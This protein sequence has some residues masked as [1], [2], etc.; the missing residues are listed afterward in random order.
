M[1]ARLGMWD[2]LPQRVQARLCYHR[3][4]LFEPSAWPLRLSP[5]LPVAYPN[6]LTWCGHHLKKP[7]TT[8]AN[9]CANGPVNTLVFFYGI[10]IS[11]YPLT[12]LYARLYDIVM[13]AACR[14]TGRVSKPGMECRARPILLSK[15]F[16]SWLEHLS[17][18]ILPYT[19]RLNYH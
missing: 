8:R 16:S 12:S 17:F 14:S 7:Q 13:M 5:S 1:P 6:H 4:K 19:N 10:S 2:C 3:G 11:P 9:T 18:Q 15:T